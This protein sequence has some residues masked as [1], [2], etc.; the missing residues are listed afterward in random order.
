MMAATTPPRT[1]GTTTVFTISQRVAPSPS[2]ASSSSSGTPRKSSRQ[3]E[4]VIGMVMIVS[5]TIAVKTVDSTLSCPCAKIGIQPRVSP[6]NGCTCCASNG[7]STKIPHRPTTTDG[8]AASMSISVPIGPRIDGGASSLRK[9]PI[10]IESGAEIRIAPNDVMTVPMIR[11]RAPNLFFTTFQSLCQR[12][13]TLNAFIAGHAPSATR[14]MIARITT[15]ADQRR[16]PGQAVEHEVADP[17]A[18]PC[19]SGRAGW[20][21]DGRGGHGPEHSSWQTAKNRASP[22]RHKLFTGCVPSRPSG[23]VRLVS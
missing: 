16:Q 20:R 19:A 13:E 22:L 15:S 9:R 18:S 8:T 11:S 1:V 3:I 6:R 12:N 14:Q 4:E 5:T 17:V 21:L 7:A 23:A 10:A 2:D